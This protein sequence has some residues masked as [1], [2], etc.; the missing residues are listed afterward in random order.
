MVFGN[1]SFQ[2]QTSS[3]SSST[4]SPSNKRQERGNHIKPL[5]ILTNAFA[6]VSNTAPM[7][8]SIPFFDQDEYLAPTPVKRVETSDSML[9]LNDPATFRPKAHGINVDVVLQQATCSGWLTKHIAPTF[10]FMKSTKRRYVVLVDRLLYAFKSETPDTYREFFELTKDSHAFVTDQFAGQ[11]Y[12]IE[13]KKM[14]QLEA[15]SWF[16]QADD[17]ESMKLWLDRIKRT[18]AWLRN[19]TSGTITKGSLT[20]ITTEDEEYSRIANN[21]NQAIYNSPTS[22]QSNVSLSDSNSW[23]HSLNSSFIATTTTITPT[24]TQFINTNYIENDS[25]LSFSSSEYSPMERNSSFSGS[26]KSSLRLA[27][28]NVPSPSNYT[29]MPAALPPQLPP[30]KCQPPP[31]PS[32][33][34]L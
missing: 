21:A 11:L 20:K 13:I 14:G 32:Y 19:G 12:C 31:I 27:R 1:L 9:D 5:E 28:P 29:I 30:P 33:A 26:R 18:I 2:S 22:S 7:S 34:Y 15:Y 23:P 17:A 16:L 8:G 25:V 10:S 4:T 24:P 6:S 3:S